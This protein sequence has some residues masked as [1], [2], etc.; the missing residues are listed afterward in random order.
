MEWTQ[1]KAIEFLSRN[2]NFERF[3]NREIG[4]IHYF[5]QD[6]QFYIAIEDI[7]VGFYV[8]DHSWDSPYYP[9]LYKLIVIATPI[10]GKLVDS[11]EYSHLTDS[12]G[13]F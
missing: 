7:G 10:L 8:A 11:I 12:S 13:V 5:Y 1:E 2:T 4:I 3:I 9:S 6:I